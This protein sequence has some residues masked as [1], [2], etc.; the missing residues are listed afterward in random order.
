MLKFNIIKCQHITIK[1][2]WWCLFTVHIFTNLCIRQNSLVV[3]NFVPRV[4]QL[5]LNARYNND[6]RK[7]LMNFISLDDTL[8]KKT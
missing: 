4:F 3:T 2:K 8:H 5:L 7:V 6:V 1:N